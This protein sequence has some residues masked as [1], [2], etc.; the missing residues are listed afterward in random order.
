MC[1]TFLDGN[2]PSCFPSSKTMHCFWTEFPLFIEMK[3][4]MENCQI[5][6]DSLHENCASPL[7]RVF[8]EGGPEPQGIPLGANPVFQTRHFLLSLTSLNRDVLHQLILD[9]TWLI[10]VN[11]VRNFGF[12]FQSLSQPQGIAL[13]RN[14]T[15]SSFS[16]PEFPFWFSS[17]LIVVKTWF[18]LVLT[19][20]CQN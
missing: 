8:T 2:Y 9:W 20:S 11:C 5:C 3:Q 10:W 18:S 16:K 7:P 4:M 19:I 15:W 13:D 17:Q 1:E 14:R 12:S 6:M